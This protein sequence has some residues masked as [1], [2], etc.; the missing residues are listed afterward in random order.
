MQIKEVSSECNKSRQFMYK[1][2][3]EKKIIKN[4]TKNKQTNK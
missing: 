2:K 4:K 3:N 1:R